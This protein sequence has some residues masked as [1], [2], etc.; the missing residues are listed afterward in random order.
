M[1]HLTTF[2]DRMD[3]GRRL[4]YR[5]RHRVQDHA[6]VLALPRG[7]VP[8]AAEVAGILGTSFDVLIVRK[9]G[10]PHH[11]EFAMGAIASG[12]AII[13]REDIIHRLGLKRQNVDAVVARERLELT[14]REQLYR[15]DKQPLHVQGRTVI[16]VD[17]GMATG[18]TMQAAVQSLRSRHAGRIIVA[19]PVA[20]ADAIERLKEEAD[21]VIALLEPDP[22][23]AVGLYYKDFSQTSDKDVVRL[24]AA[25]DDWRSDPPAK[26]MFSGADGELITA[27]HGQSRPLTGAHHDYDEFIDMIGPAFIVLLGEGTHGTHEFYQQ[28]AQITKRLIEE[29][30][31]NAVAVEADW[32]DAYRVNRFVRGE[33]RDENATDALGGFQRFPS[34]MW[35]NTDVLEFVDWLKDHNDGINSASGKVGF[36]GLDLYSLHKSMDEVIRYLE[37]VDP[38]EA[39]RAKIRYSCMDRYGPDPQNYGLLVSSGVSDGCRTEIARQLQSLHEKEVEYLSRDGPAA[40]EELFFA[41]QNARLVKNAEVYYRKMFRPDVSSWNLRDEHMME[42]LVEVI[43]HCN[44]HHG[45]AKVVVWA[46]NSHLGDAR[47]TDRARHGELNLG[48]LVREAFPHRSRSIGFT[49]YAGTVTASSGW[50]LPAKNQKVRSALPGSYELLFHQA[51]IPAFWLDLTKDSPASRALKHP[52]LE[53]AIGVVYA[54]HTERQSH[55]FM[56]RMTD[57]FDAVIHFDQTRAVEPLELGAEWTR[58]EAPETFPAGL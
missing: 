5:L 20:S 31:F 35:R 27:I 34:W 8:V 29:K 16:V 14:R 25:R 4:G 24:L 21:E 46:H 1:K 12:G 57:Q 32:P 56:A 39:R 38:G 17:D 49:T 41:Q 13:L 26:T 9:L 15:P 28:R 7:G 54:P 45:L 19:V 42:M 2:T 48:Q 47:A 10:V 22:F 30:G 50:H 58:S 40:A 23:V 11:E 33:G 36:Y 43:A 55:Y 6:V 37:R 18:S 53:R 51:G 44:N 3:A 52:R